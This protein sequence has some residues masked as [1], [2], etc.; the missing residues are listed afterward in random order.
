MKF[1]FFSTIAILLMIRN[2]VAST[3]ENP[4]NPVGGDDDLRRKGRARGRD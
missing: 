3:P 2:L 1:D 4:E